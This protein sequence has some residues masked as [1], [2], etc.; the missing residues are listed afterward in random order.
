MSA[1]RPIV[2]QKATIGAPGQASHGI[3]AQST[4]LL[5]RRVAP[6][7]RV[8]RLFR[9]SL[10]SNRAN[11]G[12]AR[13]YCNVTPFPEAVTETPRKAHQDVFIEGEGTTPACVQPERASSIES[14]S[15]V[16]SRRLEPSPRLV[17]FG[18]PGV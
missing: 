15:L 5:P 13:Q 11:R 7:R 14:G 2:V 6:R 4:T 1:G 10:T 12:D 17:V 9:T 16:I 8:W 18:C 3:V